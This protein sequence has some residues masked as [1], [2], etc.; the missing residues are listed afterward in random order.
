MER[1]F[2]WS[3]ARANSVPQLNCAIGA[4]GGNSLAVR[5]K[6]YRANSRGMA[7]KSEQFAAAWDLP[8]FGQSIRAASHH[9]LAIR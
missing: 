8:H 2:S 4:A 3:K 9:S 5:G 7:M 6:G 1:N